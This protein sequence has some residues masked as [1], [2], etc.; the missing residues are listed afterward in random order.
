MLLIT[1]SIR[2]LIDL[3]TVDFITEYYLHQSYRT[4]SE[5]D[6]LNYSVNVYEDGKVVSIVTNAG[7]HGT[8]VAVSSDLFSVT[9]F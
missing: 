4:F 9:N 6:L 3:S 7:P 1:L 2:E 5:Q 8:H